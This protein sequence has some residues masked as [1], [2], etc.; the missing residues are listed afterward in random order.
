MNGKGRAFPGRLGSGGLITNYHCSA[1]CRHC[2]YASSPRRPKDYIR[3]QTARRLG[4][5]VRREGAA[6]LHVGGG[7]PLLQPEKLFEA[8]RALRAAG[9]GIDYVETNSSWFRGEEEAA[10]ILQELRKAGAATLLV[11]ISP[12][13][14]ET[15]PLKKIRG[16]LAACRRAG[17]GAFPWVE[18]FL[19]DLALFDEETPH[20]LEEYLD[21]FGED[22]LREIPSRYWVSMRGRALPTYRPFMREQPLG[23]LL[24]QSGPCRSPWET[25]HFHV[26][27]YGNYVP[28]LCTG[29]AVDAE[30]IGRPLDPERYPFLSRLLAGGPAALLE[31]ARQKYGFRPAAAY[32]SLCEL[33][34]EIRSFLVLEAGTDSAD[35][36]PEGFYRELAA[37]KER[38]TPQPGGG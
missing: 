5:I 15:V 1:A 36:A 26:D 17:V 18:G 20:R 31:T 33:C 4:E 22:Y 13:H 9:V 24:Q 7:E 19:P 21:R 6:S 30:D 32:V 23:E 38:E 14:N 11:S 35:L 16:V 12:F 28:G 8:V 34:Q 37:Y 2:L 27:L 25:G 10:E 29:L 3:P